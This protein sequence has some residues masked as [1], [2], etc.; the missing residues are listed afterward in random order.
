MTALSF[1][2]QLSPRALAS[3]V[4]DNYDITPNGDD[5]ISIRPLKPNAPLANIT[6]GHAA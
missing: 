6:V 2:E 4:R 3:V 1:P 5:G